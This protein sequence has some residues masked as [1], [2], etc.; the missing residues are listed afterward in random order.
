MGNVTTAKRYAD[1]EAH[2]VVEVGTHAH[3]GSA[4]TLVTLTMSASYATGGDTNDLSAIFA[5]SIIDVLIFQNGTKFLAAYVAGT[6][7][8]DGK[9]KLIDSTTGSEVVATT[10]VSANVYKAIVRGT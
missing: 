4:Q 5:T 8:T 7:P 2:P 9:I 1:T 6:G 10:N 3:F